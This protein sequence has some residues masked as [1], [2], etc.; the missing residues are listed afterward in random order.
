MYN[1]LRSIKI[2]LFLSMWGY[3]DLFLRKNYCLRLLLPDLL[4]LQFF[5][6]CL[7]L[8]QVFVIADVDLALDSFMVIITIKS[9]FDQKVRLRNN[10]R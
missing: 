3:D 4:S 6:G 8:R 5:L 7:H 10:R 9:T 1:V 2:N